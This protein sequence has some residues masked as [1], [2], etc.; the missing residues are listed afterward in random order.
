MATGII[1][2]DARELGWGWI[3][4]VL[5]AVNIAAWVLL[6]AAGVGRAV[7]GGRALVVTCASRDGAGVPGGR[8]RNRRLAAAARRVPP[9]PIGAPAP[10]FAL[11]I[12]AWWVTLYGFLTGVT[13][14][15]IKPSL[16][17]GL[18]GQWLL[19]VVATQALAALGAD[20]LR[21]AG[22]VPGARLRLLRLGAARRGLFSILS[23]RS[24]CIA[25][26]SWRC[27]RRT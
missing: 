5:L 24:S 25:S 21:E 3:G 13:K 16:E 26:H 1:S 6:W 7:L 11:A 20:L 27:R 10:L 23:P 8:G 12:L 14:G 22:A 2:I 15:R 9:R 17:R 18:S 4:R 19:L